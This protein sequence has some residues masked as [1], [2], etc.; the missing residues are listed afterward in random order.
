MK[1]AVDIDDTM[2]GYIPKLVEHIIEHIKK[3]HSIERK[4]SDILDYGHE[5]FHPEWDIKRFIQE[6]EIF[7]SSRL[8]DEIP[9]IRKSVSIVKKLSKEH[10]LI[11]ITNRANRVREKTLSF[12][13]T[14]FTECFSDVI[15]AREDYDNKTKGD[16]CVDI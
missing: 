2:V 10:D 15:F 5:Y 8:F 7:E 4:I 9:C 3:Q 11:V 16:I 1:I 12:L 14:V 6:L 13:D